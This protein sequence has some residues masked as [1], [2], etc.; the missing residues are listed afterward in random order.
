MKK[1][2]YLLGV[3]TIGSSMFASSQSLVST[4]VEKKNMV[5]E[6]FTGI[7]CQYCPQGHA[8]AQQIADDNPGKVV[9]IN[10]HQGSFAVPS[11][12]EP[13]FRT[14]WGDAIAGQSGLTGY[15]A[16]TVNRHLFAGMSQGSGTAMNRGNW[17][18]AAGI[19]FQQNSPVNVGFE[20]IY[21]STTRNLT[22][23]VQIYYTAN[24][25]QNTNYINVALLQNN[26]L[27][28]QTGGN[29][30][31][32]YNHKHMLRHLL[33][34]QWGDTVT[35]TAQGTMVSRTYTYTVPENYN[36]IPVVPNNC[37]IAVFVTESHQEVY[38]GKVAPMRGGTTLIVGNMTQATTNAAT[39][40]PGDT[41]VFEFTIKSNLPGTEPFQL[42]LNGAKSWNAIFEIDGVQYTSTSIINL[43]YNIT[44]IVKV[45]I[46]SDSTAGINNYTFCMTSVN[47]PMAPPLQ[48]TFILYSNVTDLVIHNQGSWT[49]GVPANFESMYFAGIA[50]A[51][52]NTYASIGYQ[53]FVKTAN[54]DIL[55]NINSIFFNVAWT[56]PG[57]TDDIVGILSSYL[58]NGGNLFI[59]GQ[60]LGWDTW[61][62]T[63]NGT[64]ITKA[65]YT[66][67]LHT[68]YVA[69]GSS[70]N[71]LIN[72]NAT[73]PFF[74]SIAN[75]SLTDV[76]GGNMYP[77]E[78]APADAYANIIF[79][80]NNGTT[81]KSA[82]RAYN[83]TYKVV[84]LGFDPAMVSNA[85]V[86]TNII[87]TA[88]VW[89]SGFIAAASI[90]QPISC[91]GTCDG[92]VQINISGGIPP[93]AYN[94]LDPAINDSSWVTNLC[95]GEYTVVITDSGSI[96]MDTLIF[97]LSQPDMIA[98]SSI[99]SVSATC[100]TCTDGSASIT[101]TGGSG[102]HSILWND[103]QSQTTATASNLAPGEYIATVTDI[104]CSD[105]VTDTVIVGNSYNINENSNN[106]LFR[107]YP[108]PANHIL[109]IELLENNMAENIEIYD[110]LGNVVMQQNINKNSN[111]ASI[112]VTNL[113][114]GFYIIK[115]HGNK[116]YYQQPLT[117][118]R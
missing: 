77:D 65:F 46:I 29:M 41:S 93:Y 45:K 90:V 78:L 114:N 28:P 103:T 118:N 106:A 80:Y 102:T 110:M 94:W 88:T 72:A 9:L 66:N 22:V 70:T 111:M 109:N 19:I 21:D 13:D 32:N 17:S 91:N 30:G 62:A 95:A 105:I 54:S 57:L 1:L 97:S 76:Y 60:D 6:E 42:S 44:K 63:G 49:G 100:D 115:V 68:T 83:G 43:D 14:Q 52:I 71:N 5:L 25:P 108:N 31:N 33:T 116:G 64:A 59:A 73:D 48:Q 74:G 53:D 47:N 101:I 82:I 35:T 27:G 8:I 113:N 18:N 26:I 20:S 7:H 85:T 107:V 3:F 58:D 55:E 104:S 12:G 37:D 2:L 36:S 50:A 67:Y 34:G 89:F 24:S 69:D 86:R 112:N 79:Y 40:E 117:I 99:T 98:I 11:A 75:S 10:I 23:N 15:P 84:Y 38:T 39:G 61:D 4:D 81:K 87:K 16:G 51:G 92:T 96:N 56:F